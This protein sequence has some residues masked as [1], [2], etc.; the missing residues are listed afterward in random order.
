MRALPPPTDRSAFWSTQHVGAVVWDPN[1]RLPSQTGGNV[2]GAIVSPR[3]IPQN[4]QRRGEYFEEFTLGDRC[5]CCCCCLLLLL[6]VVIVDTIPAF[7]F[8]KL[9]G[10]FCNFSFA[11]GQSAKA[12][13]GPQ[14]VGMYHDA[15]PTQV[16]KKDGPNKGRMFYCC[17]ARGDTKCNFFKWASLGTGPGPPQHPSGP[18]P[19]PQQHIA[20]PAL[21]MAYFRS[22]SIAYYSGCQLRRKAPPRHQSG[23]QVWAAALIACTC[24]FC[25]SGV[26]AAARM[27][28]LRRDPY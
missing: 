3:G 23:Q 14:C 18:A 21:R 26:V 9:L 2:F 24:T 12:V 13:Q 19:A 25:L 1:N 16:V 7:N 11:N 28:V 27:R 4:D 22:R 6:S 5:C 10:Q 15:L 8:T 17:S 20:D